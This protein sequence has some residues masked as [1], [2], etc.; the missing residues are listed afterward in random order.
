MSVAITARIDYRIGSAFADP[1]LPS[2]VWWGESS[3]LGDASGGFANVQLLL[4]LAGDP[5]SARMFTVEQIMARI[6]AATATQVRIATTNMGNLVTNRPMTVRAWVEPMISDGISNS[7]TGLSVPLRPIWL[8]AATTRGVEGSIRGEIP[9]PGVGVTLIVWMSGFMWEPG[10]LN[11][12]GGVR[13]PLENI[14]G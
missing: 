11:S 7:A 8:G 9:N 2:G 12:P 14:F 6:N 4:Q 1:G 13:R 5:L 10:A 3:I